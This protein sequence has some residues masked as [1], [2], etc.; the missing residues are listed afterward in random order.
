MVN[1]AR[2]KINI[3]TETL[4]ANILSAMG[5][6]ASSAFTEGRVSG[7]STPLTPFSLN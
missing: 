4:T 1:M 3:F 2:T 7:I 6:E 5:L